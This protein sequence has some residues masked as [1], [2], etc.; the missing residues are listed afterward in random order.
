MFSVTDFLDRAKRG[1]GVDSDYALS[2][3]LGG[4]RSAISNYRH[5]KNM[6]DD[7]T[8]LALC[9]MSGDD[10]EHV[11]ACIQSMRAANDD[12]AELWR[13]MAARLEKGAAAVAILAAL[14]I[15]SIATES[16]AAQDAAALLCAQGGSLY[17][18][19]SAICRFSVRMLT[20][21]RTV[22]AGAA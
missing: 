19:L 10:P 12:V 5:G 11:A 17:I 9:R 1:A 22:L 18:M 13:R 16:E 2:K 21:R 15:G 4:T 8:I 7:S 14:A 3:L 20:T 6:P